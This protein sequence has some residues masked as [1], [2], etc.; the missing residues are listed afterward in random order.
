MILVG[1]LLPWNKCCNGV[2]FLYV[3]QASIDFG[4]PPYGGSE[5]TWRAGK[6]C[7]K[8]LAGYLAIQEVYCLQKTS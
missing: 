1:A 7:G 5:M 3:Q 6:S 8:R 2:V 4:Q